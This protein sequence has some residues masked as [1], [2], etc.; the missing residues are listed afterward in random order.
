MI[1]MLLPIS[2]LTSRLQSLV[3]IEELHTPLHKHIYKNDI[4][5]V[6][7][8]TFMTAKDVLLQCGKEKGD[9]SEGLFLFGALIFLVH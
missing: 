6:Y 5:T 4:P 9:H 8:Q 1:I 2:T 3:S 7:T